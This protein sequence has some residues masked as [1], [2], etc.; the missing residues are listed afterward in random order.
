[1]RVDF[2]F[3]AP[4]RLAQAVSTTVKQIDRGVRLLVYCPDQKAAQ[5]YGRT[6]WRTPGPTFIAHERLSPEAIPDLPVYLLDDDNWQ[7]VDETMFQNRWLLNLH[8]ECPPLDQPQCTRIL[9]FVGT[10]E[11]AMRSARVRWRQY[12]KAGYEV[13]GHDLSSLQTAAN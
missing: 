2:A 3:H 1:M 6:L 10:D 11:E 8:Y 5:A 4:D 9:D 12:V 13:I 7:A